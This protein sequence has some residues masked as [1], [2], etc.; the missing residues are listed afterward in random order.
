MPDILNNLT[1]ITLSQWIDAGL[2]YS[3][4]QHD[5]ERYFLRTQRGCR[6]T[7]VQIEWNSILE[8]R[9]AVLRAKYGDPSPRGPQIFADVVQPDPEAYTYFSNYKLCDGRSLPLEAINEYCANAA[10]LNAVGKVANDSITMRRNKGNAVHV[11]EVWNIVANGVTAISRDTWAHTL[12]SNSR[13]LRDKY[14]QYMKEGF[15]C[16]IHRNFCNQSARKVSP[17]MEDLFIALYTTR[18]RHFAK[19]VRDLYLQFLSGSVEVANISTGELFNRADFFDEESRP[20]YISE[21]TTWSYL[22]KPGSQQAIRKFRDSSINFNTK[23]L[24][25]NQRHKPNFTLSKISFDDRDLPRKTANGFEVKAYYA[26][27]PLSQ[28]FVGWAYSREKNIPLILDCF[29]SVLSFCQKHNLPWPAEAEVER[30]LMTQLKDPL[31]QMFAHVRWC[32]PQNSREKRAE[33]GNKI[34]KYGSEKL[35]QENIGRWSNRGEAYK[36]NEDNTKIYE[37]NDLV[38]DDIYISNHHNMQIHPDFPDKTRLQVLREMVNP[39]LGPPNLRIILKNIGNRTETSIRNFDFVRVQYKNYTIDSD[40]VL[41]MLAPNNYDVEAYWLPDE[42]GEIKEVYLY[43][44]DK[45]LC[46]A[47]LVETYNEAQVE[48]TERDEE[49]RT[50]QAKRQAHAR[51]RVEDRAKNI[52]RVEVIRNMPDYSDIIPEVVNVTPESAPEEFNSNDIIDDSD[53]WKELGMSSI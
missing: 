32:N 34:R 23:S 5:K 11:N 13:R 38:A 10:V 6:N 26:Y 42:N 17:L 8:K 22:A 4:Y 52:P 35:L 47:N 19:T 51:K 21:S 46:Q 15:E 45:Y 37:Y 41:S 36:I 7:E 29:K 31:E 28:C 43:Q 2:T 9:K 30:H 14:R 53:Y 25:Y 12:P 39:V 16:L 24:P 49:I 27:E 3:Q 48:R 33:H 20:L 40:K 50:D 44:S 1:V 18:N